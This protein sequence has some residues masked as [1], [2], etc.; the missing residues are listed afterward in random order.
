MASSALFLVQQHYAEMN[1]AIGASRAQAKRLLIVGLS[2]SELASLLTEFSQV[3]PG[4]GTL[5][6]MIQKLT[7]DLLRLLVLA[8]LACPL[9]LFQRFQ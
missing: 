4:F 5:G 1:Q 3:L 2:L 6:M 7:V 9:G 8:G